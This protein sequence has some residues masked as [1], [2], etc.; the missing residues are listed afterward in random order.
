MSIFKDC[1]I[2]GVYGKELT[3]GDALRIGRGLAAMLPPGGT[4]RVGG[5]VRVSTPALKMCIRDSCM[6]LAA[7]GRALSEM[8]RESESLIP[9]GVR[10]YPLTR[11]GERFPFVDPNFE[12]FYFG[13]I[14]EGRLYPAL[15]EGVGFAE[16]FALEKMQAIG[17]P[18]GDSVCTAGGASRSP[19]WLKIRA[20]ILN[21]RLICL[22]YT[23]RCA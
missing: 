15:M 1:D 4:M 6:N 5:D 23:S 8:D 14:L 12:P 11:R 16:R 21:R 3:D 9:T 18:V 13:D 10:C 2:R 7:N 22:L 17:C 20:A 19:L